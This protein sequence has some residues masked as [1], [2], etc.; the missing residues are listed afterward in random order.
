[1]VRKRIAVCGGTG[2]SREG[3]RRILEGLGFLVCALVAQPSDLLANDDIDAFL[4][5]GGSEEQATVATRELRARFP[6][7]KIIALLD[8]AHPEAI[9]NVLEAGADEFLT[10]AIEPDALAGALNLSLADL[11]SLRFA[12]GSAR[13][14][15][16]A[17]VDVPLTSRER[18]ILDLMAIGDGNAEIGEK[19]DITEPTVKVHMRNIFRKLDK[20]N[21]TQVALWAAAHGFGADKT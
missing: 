5:D 14:R 1:M 18:E 21:R 20:A 19:L 17:Q 6:S 7:A 15:A 9:R 11:S 2:I 12:D 4:V 16:G 3:L 13:V 10:K 8:A